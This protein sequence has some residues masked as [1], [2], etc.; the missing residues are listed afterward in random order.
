[1]DNNNAESTESLNTVRCTCDGSPSGDADCKACGGFE[2]AESI[3]AAEA[4]KIVETLHSDSLGVVA[5]DVTSERADKLVNKSGVQ[6]TTELLLLLARF[7]ADV[8]DTAG[9]NM[10]ASFAV[11]FAAVECEVV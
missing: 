3:T 6:T 5:A 1:M 8:D 7:H 2:P 9:A 10:L 4:V 11:Q